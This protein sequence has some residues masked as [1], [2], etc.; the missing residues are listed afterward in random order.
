[1]RSTIRAALAGLAAA[2]T[3]TALVACAP[4]GDDSPDEL[5]LTVGVDTFDFE[6][7]G[8]WDPAQDSDRKSVV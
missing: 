3:L 6:G 1:M 5:T 8:N 2:A 4:S 7:L